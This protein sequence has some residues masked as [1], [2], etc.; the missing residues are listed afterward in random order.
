MD[1]FQAFISIVGL[2][3]AVGS[4]VLAFV[5]ALQS[6]KIKELTDI[7]IELKDQTVIM[8]QSLD[9]LKSQ[10]LTMERSLEIERLTS[11]PNRMPFFV[12]STVTKSVG[13]HLIYINLRNV[14]RQALNVFLKEQNADNFKVTF[15]GKLIHEG[16]EMT[17]NV[18]F[19]H[20][21][22]FP[23]G[24]KISHK[25]YFGLESQQNIRIWNEDLEF[26]IDPP[27]DFILPS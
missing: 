2:A 23:I 17:I 25:S 12:M 18:A 15:N 24:F 21:P 16:H 27:H 14:G 19:I 1:N 9:E 4:L 8:Q 22:K 20:E 5:V 26:D 13:A 10:T 7:I 3:V 6:K 11:V